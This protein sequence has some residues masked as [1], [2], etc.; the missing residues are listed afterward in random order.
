M[1]VFFLFCLGLTSKRFATQSKVCLIG[2]QVR[3]LRGRRHPL[4]GTGVRSSMLVTRRPDECRMRT[5]FCLPYPIPF[6]LIV[7][8]VNPSVRACIRTTLGV[9]VPCWTSLT[10]RLTS[11]TWPCIKDGYFSSAVH[12]LLQAAPKL[13]EEETFKG[14]AGHEITPFMQLKDELMTCIDLTFSPICAATASAACVVDLRALVKPSVPPEAHACTR[15]SASDSVIM[16]LLL[17]LST[18]ITPTCT[19]ICILHPKPANINQYMTSV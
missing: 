1:G 19:A 8:V 16:V 5:A 2:T 17:V 6:T 15:P 3:R 10:R 4:C 12:L 11:P 14:G 13:H 18:D 7:T 9:Y